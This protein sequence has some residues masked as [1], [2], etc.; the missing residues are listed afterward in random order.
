M[1]KKQSR[2]LFLCEADGFNKGTWSQSIAWHLEHMSK[3]E[4]AFTVPLQQAADVLKKRIWD[5]KY[6]CVNCQLHIVSQ[7]VLKLNDKPV[8]RPLPVPDR[9]GP[10]FDA[11]MIAR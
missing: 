8:Q 11:F 10:L 9:H 7:P 2:I 1:I 5:C 6:F 4:Q 3:L